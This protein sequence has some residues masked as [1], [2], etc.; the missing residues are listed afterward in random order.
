M[1]W[2]YPQTYEHIT[3]RG[4]L[5]GIGTRPASFLLISTLPVNDQSCLIQGTAPVAEEEE[6][7][8]QMLSSSTSTNMPTVI[9]YGR[10]AGDP[11]ATKKCLQLARLGLGKVKLYS[12]G[13]FEW[14]LLQDIYGTDAFPTTG[15]CDDP[16]KYGDPF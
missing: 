16:L 12:G 7:I 2:Q 15:R 6:H 14:L 4:L 10:N 5:L 13:L 8:N 9:V 1:S 3:Y 11:L